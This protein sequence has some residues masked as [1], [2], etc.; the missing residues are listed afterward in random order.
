MQRH[1]GAHVVHQAG[2]DKPSVT[3]VD[4]AATVGHDGGAFRR[5]VGEIGRDPVATFGCDQ[6]AN[7]GG[8]FGGIAY[9][10]LRQP[11]LDLV[12]ER[13]ANRPDGDHY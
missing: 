10:Q 3:L 13:V 2:A 8:G 4:D 6:R 7:L 5:R 11:V 9:A 12:D 1:A